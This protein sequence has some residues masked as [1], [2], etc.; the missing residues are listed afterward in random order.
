MAEKAESA[1]DSK[2]RDDQDEEEGSKGS[3][4]TSADGMAD[5]YAIGLQEVV[6]L[7]AVNVAM[8]KNSQVRSRT[9]VPAWDV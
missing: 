6:D 7:N 9:L 3:K 2:S 5:I 8:D 4:R 1:S